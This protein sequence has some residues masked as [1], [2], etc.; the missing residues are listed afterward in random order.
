MGE[1]ATF[2]TNAFDNS[3]F[4]N[5]TSKVPP[6]FQVFDASFLAVLGEN[7][8]IREIARNDTFAF[9]HEAPV[10]YPST[11]EVFF[12]SNAGSKLGMSD[13]EHN[14]AVSKISLEEAERALAVENRSVV[15]VPFTT[16]D[17]PETIQMTNGGTGPFR[18]SLAFVTSGRGPR[19]PSVALV[20][21]LP[22]YN[23]TVLLDN[24]Y[25]RQFNSLN[26]I[27]I[28]PSGRFFFTDVSYGYVNDFRPQPM[29]PEQVY[30]FDPESGSIRVVADGFEKC[31]GIAFTQDGALAYIT[32]TGVAG[33]SG[34]DQTKP[35]TI[36]AY[37]VDPQT[38]AFK[39][40]RVFAYTDAGI[41]DGIQVDANGNVYSG[42]GDG[43]QVW[44]SS[45]DLIGKFFVGTTA[46]QMVFAGDGRLVI[47]AETAVYLAKIAAKGFPLGAH[48]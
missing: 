6:F 8:S 27:K 1:N 25:G 45:G 44:N 15:N 40:R 16:I 10:Y 31:N 9:A 7:A 33:K 13:L 20:N 39:N 14:N 34:L 42:T 18:G 2:R 11:D 41:P 32:D 22:P 37:D 48:P 29:M 19:P 26:D 17:L 24:F 28:H 3:S 5:P 36:Y 38:H 43:V 46:A 23:A 30:R 47:L 35:S 4:F 21:P 12:A